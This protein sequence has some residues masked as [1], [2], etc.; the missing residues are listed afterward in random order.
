M[1]AWHFH[2][3]P[4]RKVYM[5]D[6]FLS[7]SE[8]LFVT[9]HHCTKYTDLHLMLNSALCWLEQFSWNS[10]WRR[11]TIPACTQCIFKNWLFVIYYSWYSSHPPRTL[12]LHACR[13]PPPQ[14]A[15]LFLFNNSAFFC[16][17]NII[18]KSFQ[19]LRLS[20]SLFCDWLP[21]LVQD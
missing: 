20:S 19:T 17:E 13:G 18:F 6:F 10:L 3:M 5:K 1:P 21:H 14:R 9:S 16:L 4:S 12:H 7:V 2:S 11:S 8:V 15:N